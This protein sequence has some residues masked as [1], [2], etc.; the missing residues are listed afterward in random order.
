[1]PFQPEKITREH[2]LKAAQKIDSGEVEVI[3]STKFDVIINGKPYPPK[4]LMRLAHEQATGEY[5]WNPGGGE[6]TN[7]Y[8]KQLGFEIQSKN[9]VGDP[10]QNL[11][12][13][14][15]DRIRK[16]N[17][18]DELYKFKLI[19]DFQSKWDIEA[20]DF[21]AMIKRIDFGNLLFFN[22][23]GVVKDLSNRYPEEIRNAFKI[24]YN[25][26]IK[27]EE[28]IKTFQAKAAELYATVNTLSHN[29]DERTIAT[30]L[31][32]HNP[33]T[34][35]FYKSS[36]YSKYC[37]L[38]NIKKAKSGDRYLH[39]LELVDQLI[40]NYI[41][42]D[43][44][45]K[46][47]HS[48]YLETIIFKDEQ[49]KVL[50]Q[51]ILYQSLD[52]AQPE[53]ISYYL[54]GSV[55]K[56]NNGKP[57]DQLQ[58]FL[59][60]GIWENGHDGKNVDLVK[61][62]KPGSRIAVKAVHTL[63]KTRS[64]M[65]IKARGE[66]IENEE[67]GHILKVNWE[68][69]LNPFIVDFSGG[70]WGTAHQVTNQ[71]HVNAIF[72]NSTGTIIDINTYNTTMSTAP[73]NQILFGPPGTGKTYHTMDKALE[74]V[75]VNV[76]KLSREAIK[77]EYEKRVSEGQIVFTTF[78]QSMNYEDFI[79]G[80]KPVL[81]SDENEHI[82]YHIEDGILK[83]LSRKA[84]AEYYKNDIATKEKE[85]KPID[86]LQLYD[87]AWDH[88]VQSVQDNLDKGKPLELSSSSGKTLDVIKITPQGNLLVKPKSELSEDYT[89]SYMRTQKLFDA[90][91]DLSTVKNH[92]KAFRQIIGGANSTTYWCV[93]NYLNNWVNDKANEDTI[94]VEA[95]HINEALVKFDNQ[96]V[97]A[98]AS[99]NIKPFVLII[100]EIN[101]GNVSKVFGELITLIEKDKRLGKEEA[102]EV[103]LPYSK[104][105]FGVPLNLYIIG[106]MNTADRSV[107]A[108]DTALR[109]RFSF[110]EILS[111]T[112]LL[113]PGFL[114]WRL[115]WDYKGIPW[116]NKEFEVKEET[117][118]NL[119]GAT[120]ELWNDRKDIWE[121]MKKEGMSQ[122]QTS[123]F[124]KYE[125]TGINLQ[126]ILQTLN[127]RI[128]I[129]KDRDHQI[130]HAYFMNVRT[131][132][133]L[134]NVFKDNIIPLLQEY[135][136]GD[137]YKIQLVLGKGFIQSSSS[138]IKFAI[139]EED[140]YEDKILYS[141]ATSAFDSEMSLETALAE[142]KISK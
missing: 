12:K 81:D 88:L 55:W 42:E 99:G 39:Y 31:T 4:D 14:Y 85:S 38:L 27:L 116:N 113:S 7:K 141:I 20:K 48:K 92:D 115:L 109:R 110:E 59:K 17:N 74:I 93:V 124:D 87:E 140:E 40:E 30:Y 105:K 43:E 9:N 11:I 128:E 26:D 44:E 134:I 71:E 102:I 82:R 80:I 6:P 53:P 78:H 131:P 142:M 25:D 118:L 84:V 72:N 137:Y 21:Y 100:D 36:F 45:L 61:A 117:L 108:L 34:Y 51:D 107:E 56:D 133:D 2:V 35:T 95:L 19:I 1:M 94:M 126:K 138:A 16:N 103:T 127:K 13:I 130:G 24:L 49:F 8:L 15:K 97:K 50:A 58:R 62:I 23:I 65:T 70:Y 139:E 119:L 120:E 121:R 136:F 125:F 101:R 104:E 37:K 3:P 96:I 75:G 67:D 54:A 98:N 132:S 69:K 76:K 57:V 106:T 91:P 83:R 79:E 41:D 114:Y 22:A 123:Y 111:D 28:R 29:Q 10:V 64:V 47:L 77:E 33:S 46:Q 32:F 112:S 63:E 18:Q 5:L 66:V 89:V 60:D 122:I 90:Y 135:F 52:L 73:L 68:E 86:R 129:L